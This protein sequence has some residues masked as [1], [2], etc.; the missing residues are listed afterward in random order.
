MSDWSLFVGRLEDGALDALNSAP[1]LIYILA[2]DVAA[3]V[4]LL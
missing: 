3:V 2:W 4:A 1:V